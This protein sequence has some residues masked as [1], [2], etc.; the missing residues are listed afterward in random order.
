MAALPVNPETPASTVVEV[1]LNAKQ[2]AFVDY[3]SR[4]H[5][6]SL[7]EAIRLAIDNADEQHRKHF[8]DLLDRL[9]GTWEHGDPLE[10]Q[11]KMRAEWD[12]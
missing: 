12:R 11:L 3:L 7:D 1:T 9:K 2:K 4:L 10:W 8:A 5:K 6:V